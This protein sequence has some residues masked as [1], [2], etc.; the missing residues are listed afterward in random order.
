M[1]GIEGP[2]SSLRKPHLLDK[3]RRLQISYN[4]IKK[5]FNEGG[6]SL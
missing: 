6:I 3:E 2:W 1:S 4:L 5:L